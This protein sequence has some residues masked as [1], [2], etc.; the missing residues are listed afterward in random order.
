MKSTAKNV[1]ING[2]WLNK[3]APIPEVTISFDDGSEMVITETFFRTHNFKLGDKV[4][5]AI[6]DSSEQSIIE[7]EK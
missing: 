1:E 3:H 7:E 2:F 5:I 4:T 6:S